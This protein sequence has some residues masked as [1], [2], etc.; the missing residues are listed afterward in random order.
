[1]VTFMSSHERTRKSL[2]G[3][4]QKKA[5]ADAPLSPLP[6]QENDDQQPV[7]EDALPPAPYRYVSSWQKAAEYEQDDAARETVVNT[8]SVALKLDA[9]LKAPVQETEGQVEAEPRCLNEGAA[10]KFSAALHPQAQPA[11]GVVP[12]APAEVAQAAVSNIAIPV[13]QPA[14]APCFA[15]RLQQK[16]E[17]ALCAATA[18][19]AT[20]TSRHG[21]E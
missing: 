9:I 5:A 1:M 3:L 8:G 6:A 13:L 7:K 10:E 4:F 17:G 21:N 12:P 18:P 16:V 20:A 19:Y 11:P 14:R 2:F 15:K